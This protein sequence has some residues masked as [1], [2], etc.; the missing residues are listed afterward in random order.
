VTLLAARALTKRY[1]ERVALRDVSLTLR[2]GEVLALLGPNGAGKTT[3]LRLLAGVLRPTAGTVEVDGVVQGPASWPGARNRIGFLTEMPGLW[4]RLSVE[5]NLLT[6]AR[7]YAIPA[8]SRRVAVL[9]DRVGLADRAADP[10]GA[11]SKGMRQKVALA[12][13]LLHEPPIVL[14]DEPTAGLD[15]AMTRTVRELVADLRAAGR[16]V[17]LSTH[18]LDEA[19]RV[20]DRIAVLTQTLVALDA[21]A[22]LRARWGARRVAVTLDGE[23]AALRPAA[24][25]AGALDVETEGSTLRC[26]L[27]DP[28]AD[29]PAL[30][31]ALVQAGARIRRVV[32]EEAGLEDIY[33]ALVRDAGAPT[34]TGGAP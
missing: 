14:L 5:E 3:T 2:S 26:A 34:R 28:D 21:P 15:P 29:T 24:T 13:A 16:A 1:G 33:L 8:P 32:P 25:A 31:L 23:A 30:V 18:N 11:L 12:R 27:P 19:E 4:D 7:L 9:L 6:Y 10:A 22:A 17:L 20:A